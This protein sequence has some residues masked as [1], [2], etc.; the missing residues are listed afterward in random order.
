LSAV[1]EQIPL[2]ELITVPGLLL[3]KYQAV[4]LAIVLREQIKYIYGKFWFVF[5]ALALALTD[6]LLVIGIPTIH[7]HPTAKSFTEGW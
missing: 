5:F 2:L 3:K 1:L 7:R 6:R 4:A